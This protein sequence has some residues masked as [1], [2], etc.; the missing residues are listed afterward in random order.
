MVT[1]EH[2]HEVIERDFDAEEMKARV[3][4]IGVGLVFLGFIVAYLCTMPVA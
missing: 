3:R 2:E 1:T 4:M